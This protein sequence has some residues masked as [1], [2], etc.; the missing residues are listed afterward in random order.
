MS[1]KKSILARLL[2]NEN[3]T[4]IH[5][6][7]ETA[8]F[9]T[10]NR[11]L[12]LPLWNDEKVYDLLIGHEVAHALYTPFEGWSEALKKNNNIP[13]SIYNVVEDVRIERLIQILYPGLV[14]SF[15][16]GYKY[17]N[18]KDF[19]DLKGQSYIRICDYNFIDR[20]N[21]KA[22]LR[23]LIDVEFTEYEQTIFDKC[24]SAET[25]DDVEVVVEE[26]YQYMK[27]SLK[28]LKIES[29]D[30]QNSFE[31]NEDSIHSSSSKYSQ[32]SF[33]SNEDFD[34]NTYNKFLESKTD[35]IFEEKKSKELLNRDVYGNIEKVSQ[36]INSEQK[37]NM[38]V[39]Y[40]KFRE[41]Y[42]RCKIAYDKSSVLKFINENKNVVMNMVKEFELRKSAYRYS[43]S[44]VSKSGSIDI[45]KLFKYKLTDDIFLRKTKLADSKNHG[46]V[47]LIDY[48]GSMSVC[49]K[50]VISQ[51]L[52]LA[53]FCKKTNIPFELYG[54]SGNTH[55]NYNSFIDNHIIINSNVFEL[56]SSFMSKEHYDEAFGELVRQINKKHHSVVGL[57]TLG[58]TP[59]NESLILMYDVLRNFK[60]KSKAE[61]ISFIVLTD[62]A[63]NALFFAE[64]GMKT[65]NVKKIKVDNNFVEYSGGLSETLLNDMRNKNLFDSALCYDLSDNKRFLYRVPSN[66]KNFEKVKKTFSKEGAVSL[67]KIY[68][69]DNYI[70]IKNTSSNL[71]IDNEDYEIE[72]NASRKDIEKA[73]K[74]HSSSKKKSRVLAV[75]FAESIA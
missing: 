62:G 48:S 70:F 7:Y 69:Y 39:P 63:A 65:G 18:E 35:K 49:I 72:E 46:M 12:G 27:D 75:K 71:D 9:D 55:C 32:N 61:K 40:V 10:K 15:I 11:V 6:S 8:F 19:F 73:F 31:L 59:L 58:S 16:K 28:H 34:T 26:I 50:S 43:K 47:M 45:N 56:L 13:K 23:E 53:M 3:I 21:L 52:V 37:Q 30:S 42:N 1:E 22:K 60:N 74:K 51:A 41:M 25:W 5:G 33:E 29:E 54:F 24:C 66:Y 36:G 68:G 14:S 64:N 67:K 44:V 4:I 17:L 57:E 38:F 2:A 20:L